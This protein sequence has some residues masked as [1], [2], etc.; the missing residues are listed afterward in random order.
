MRTS[1]QG[2]AFIEH[3]EG[4]VLKAYRD[5]VGIWTIG[6]GLTKASGV[7]SPKAGMQITRK[8]ASRLMQIALERNYEPRVRAAMP[9]AKQH[10]FDA[11]VS[12]DFNTGAIARASWV[13]A[14]AI[15]NAADARRRLALWNKAKGRV[16][17]GLVRRR[18]EEADILLEGRYPDPLPHLKGPGIARIVVSLSGGEIA[19]LRGAFDALGYPMTSRVG[20]FDKLA[21]RAF[22]RDHHLT[23]DGI[24]GK[25]TISTVRRM[26]DA[27]RALDAP[28][29]TLVSGGSVVAVKPV[30]LPPAETSII[31]VVFLALVAIWVARRAWDYR[32]A[33][34]AKVQTRLPRLARFLRRF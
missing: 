33:I 31:I 2:I 1:E 24:V 21:I 23:V 4:V 20:T 34:A 15:G 29:A 14:W 28:A 12:F 18:R 32:D 16:L 30:E 6:A 7:V 13:K 26:R 17:P 9:Q 27:R 22:Q 25:A 8:D 19:D 5:P 3:H 11:G 10:A